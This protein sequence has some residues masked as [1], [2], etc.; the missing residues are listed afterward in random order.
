M[1]NLENTSPTPEVKSMDDIFGA[2]DAGNM[3]L[4][5]QI[6]DE[7]EN[8]PVAPPPQVK[9]TFQLKQPLKKQVGQTEVKEAKTDTKVNISQEVV[10]PEKDEVTV[11]RLKALEKQIKELLKGQNGVKV[12][13]APENPEPIDFTKI[14]EEDVYD[15]DVPIEAISHDIPDFL[16]VDLK[17]KNYAARWI[18]KT[19]RR[20]GPMLAKGWTY[21]E[22]QDLVDATTLKE[23]VDE[24]GH[25]RFDDVILCKCPKVKYFGQLRANHERA[26]NMVNSRRHHQKAKEAVQGALINAPKTGKPGK[27]ARDYIAENKL[28]V[29]VPGEK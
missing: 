18:H 29:Y 27:N 23:T 25:F 20:L 21:V 11:E 19:P 10:I 13:K 2:S 22:E 16:T 6:A 26:M 15:L 7:F 9:S 4:A 1:S 14:S 17:D 3:D 12:T 24:N 8:K 28:E 5:S